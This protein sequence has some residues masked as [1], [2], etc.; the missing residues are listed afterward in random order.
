MFGDLEQNIKIRQV[1]K[2]LNQALQLCFKYTEIVCIR[3][4]TAAVPRAAHGISMAAL[5]PPA[6]GQ[7]A[8]GGLLG[9]VAVAA[10]AALLV[11]AAWIHLL[12]KYMHLL[13]RGLSLT[14]KWLK[15]MVLLTA[16]C[17]VPGV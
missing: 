4:V 17:M 1:I 5:L 7:A 2:L 6:A 13:I 8:R 3:T 11:V 10:H 14:V 15:C 9:A 12:G 16:D